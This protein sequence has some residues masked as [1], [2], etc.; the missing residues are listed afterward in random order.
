MTKCARALVVEVSITA[1]RKLCIIPRS[2]TLANFPSR[3]RDLCSLLQHR[4]YRGSTIQDMDLRAVED[5][6]SPYRSRSNRCQ[7]M[8]MIPVNRLLLPYDNQCGGVASIVHC[9]DTRGAH[10]AQRRR[11]VRPGRGAV[12]AADTDGGP[13]ISEIN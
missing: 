2:P 11:T 7:I 12:S 4:R 1:G 13:T 3:A 10:V 5:G 8:S 6:A 9:E